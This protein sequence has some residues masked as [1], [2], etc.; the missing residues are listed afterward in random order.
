[1]EL[2]PT[3]RLA[4]VLLLADLVVLAALARLAPALAQLG[5]VATWLEAGLRLPVL[6]GAGMLLAPGGPRGAAALVSLAPATFLTLRG[7]LE[8]PGAPP[9]LLAMATPSWLALAYGAVL[10]ALLTWTSLAPGVALGTKEVKYQAALRRQLALAW[11]EWPFLS[12]AFF[13]LVLAALGETSVPYCTGKALDVLRH[14]DGPTAFATAISFV[15]LASASSSLFAGCRGG[16]FSFI[17]ARLTLRTRDRLFSGLVHQDLAFFQ[18][19]TAADL[20]SRLATDVPLAS[21][22]VPGSANIALRNLGKVL[23]LSAFMLALSPRLTL[24]ALLEVPLAI[25][26]HKV[27]NAR[28][29]MLQQAVLDATAGTGMVV[30]EAISSIE[31]VRAFAGEE[32]EERRYGQALTKMLGLRDQRDMETAIFLLIRRALQLAVQALVLYCGHQQLR[33][34]TLTAGGLVAFILYQNNAGSSVQLCPTQALAYAYGDLLSNVAAAH[35]IFDYLD[36][37]PAVGTGGTS[38]P[39]TLQGHVTFQ[40]VSFAYPTRPEH[41]VLQD[42]SFELRPGEVTALAGLNGSGKSTCAGLLQRFYEPTA[43]EV[44]LDG[45][46]LRDYRHRYLHRQVALVGQEPVLFSGSIRDNIAYGLEDCR[47]EEIIAAAEAAGALDFISALDQGFDTDVG[48]RGDQ[49]SAGQK[50]R[51]AIARALVR[52]PTVLILDEATSA[53]DGDGD[54]ALQQWVQS[55]GDRTVLL[56]THHPW[57]L[58]KADRIVVLEHGTVAEM[59]TPAELT[60]C[61]GPYSRLLQR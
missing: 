60:A 52:C 18:Q 22:V 11:P 59:G 24:L 50:Q 3:L 25:A 43:G 14:G 13:F 5:L 20:A 39:A 61:G 57:M 26:A 42:V 36:R 32:E 54:V 37:E 29:Q 9:V 19:T 34:G 33:E 49:L 53:L 16:L 30:Q 46:P 28:H 45:V 2:L 12:G 35:K 10:L 40:H 21:R 47:E 1:M 58:E 38:E 27:Y 4:C 15:C 48:E 56:I 55:G 51:V 41:L 31:T 8:L 44:L 7:C 17:M 6:V 23:G